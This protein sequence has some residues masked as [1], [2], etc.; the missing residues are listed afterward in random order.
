[1]GATVGLSPAGMRIGGVYTPP[2]QRGHGYASALTA[3]LSQALLDDGLRF[4]TLNTDL[5]N[6][7]SNKIYPAI[8]YYL[9]ADQTMYE[10]EGQDHNE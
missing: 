4:C 7:T 8:G 1:M 6:P 3:A 9:V 2:E 10:V 5:K